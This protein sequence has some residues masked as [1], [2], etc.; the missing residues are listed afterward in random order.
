M[1]TE[2]DQYLAQQ[3]ELLNQQNKLLAEQNALLSQRI[4]SLKNILNSHNEL[5]QVL[6]NK[7]NSLETENEM[8]KE[9]ISAMK[10]ELLKLEQGK[11]SQEY[12]QRYLNNWSSQYQQLWTQ[13]LN[14]LDLENIVSRLVQK[15]IASI[16][17]EINR[18]K[19]RFETMISKF[20]QMPVELDFYDNLIKF[21]VSSF[22]FSD[23]CWWGL[24]KLV[25]KFIKHFHRH[26]ILVP[27]RCASS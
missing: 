12:Q 1:Q 20:E 15:Q 7:I 13:A 19:M 22:L 14:G 27:R 6:N 21:F 5:E 17:E 3:N 16:L 11:F 24:Q 2:I 9:L 23:G 8:L 26:I 4:D 10:S 18:L 25:A